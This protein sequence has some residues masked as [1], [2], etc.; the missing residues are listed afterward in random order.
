VGCAATAIPCIFAAIVRGAIVRRA[1]LGGTSR[2]TGGSGGE[3]EGVRGAL[4]VV[5][6]GAA[7]A[8]PV[9][10]LGDVHILVAAGA[11]PTAVAHVILTDFVPGVA[12][13]A[14][15]CTF[16]CRIAA[17]VRSSAAAA[18]IWSGGCPWSDVGG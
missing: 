1:I 17:G 4:L 18:M 14:L 6:V 10:P 9:G 11:S 13:S 7:A 3:G 5:G 15:F 8:E 12:T 16:R 2:A